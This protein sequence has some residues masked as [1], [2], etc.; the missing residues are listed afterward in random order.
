MPDVLPFPG[1]RYSDS[2]ALA[3]LVCPPYDVISP[4]E[5]DEL[6]RRHPHNAVRLELAK[7]EAGQAYASARDAYESWLDQGVLQRDAEATF[8]VYRQDFNGPDGQRRR[9]AGVIGALRLEP[10]GA[11]GVLPHERTMPGPK[12][13]RLALLEALP[14][15]ISPI[16]AIYRGG[17][18]LRPLLDTLAERAPRGS[19]VDSSGI[20]HRLWPVTAAAE[21]SVLADALGA[22]PIVI[23]DG[24][25]RYETALSFAAKDPTHPGRSSIMTFLVDVDREDLVVLPY[26]RILKT[27]RGWQSLAESLQNTFPYTA[28]AHE[29]IAG[30]L[31]AS[32]ADHP[33]VFVG[34]D[35]A[36]LIELS[37]AE[38]GAG[39]GTT[40][41]AARRLD[42][43]VLHDLVIPAVVNGAMDDMSFTRDAA[44]VLS[45]AREDEGTAGILMRAVDPVE[46]VD[47]ATSGE[48]MPQKASYFWP[49]ALTGLVFHELR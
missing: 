36:V 15:N 7:L 23:A 5:Q 20:R 12:R 26:H 31:D 47:V 25:H 27:P 24:H 13:D 16:Y 37:D 48:R 4:A 49:K 32:R 9:V 22:G 39:L 11:G 40:A 41:G 1:V 3:E 19:F 29:E 43:V 38:V 17:G 10:L 45:R 44:E 30:A 18:R 2:A 21:A 33:M 28:L 42:V 35:R 6:H 8:Y 14:V 34:S 46:V